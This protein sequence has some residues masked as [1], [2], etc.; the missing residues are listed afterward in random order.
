LLGS[1]R[2]HLAAAASLHVNAVV[3]WETDQAR[4]HAAR[5]PRQGSKPVWLGNLVDLERIKWE[6]TDALTPGRHTVEF[7]FKYH[8]GG[9]D[10]DRR[11]G[12]AG[13]YPG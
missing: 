4:L 12:K 6:G 8:R 7:D 1:R 3:Y 10:R 13:S 11:E 2:E 5:L 9:G